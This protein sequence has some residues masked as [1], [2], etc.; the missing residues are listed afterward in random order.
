LTVFLL[1]NVAAAIVTISW[2]SPIPEIATMLPFF[3]KGNIS[4]CVYDGV[5]MRRGRVTLRFE[6]GERE[7]GIEGVQAARGE[8]A[9]AAI[10]VVFSGILVERWT[11]GRPRKRRYCLQERVGHQRRRSPWRKRWERRGGGKDYGYKLG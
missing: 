2:V 4:G 9:G 6:E 5:V 1:A 10:L 11:E 7:L 3:A 8:I